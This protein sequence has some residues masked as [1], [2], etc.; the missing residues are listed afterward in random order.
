[1]RRAPPS[2]LLERAGQIDMVALQWVA[3]GGVCLYLAVP[4]ATGPGETQ[5]QLV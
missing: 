3:S 1:M 4:L 2:E 5:G